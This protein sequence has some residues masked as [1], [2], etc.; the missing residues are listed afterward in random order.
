M[1][2]FFVSY[3]YKTS[4]GFGSGSIVLPL[5]GFPNKLK[6]EKEVKSSMDSEA[7]ICFA[8]I[9]ELTKADYNDYIAK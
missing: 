3:T 1:R 5:I 8:N 9:I 4:N 7:S 6:L 2:Y